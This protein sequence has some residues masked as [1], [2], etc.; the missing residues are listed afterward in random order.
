MQQAALK[1]D[2]LSKLAEEFLSQK[3]IKALNNK[4]E[5][6]VLANGSEIT[7]LSLYLGTRIGLD[8]LEEGVRKLANRINAIDDKIEYALSHFLKLDLY[9]NEFD[10]LQ[11]KSQECVIVCYPLVSA[12]NYE[13]IMKN[14][15]QYGVFEMGAVP[16]ELT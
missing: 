8:K 12:K 14:P 7:H 9:Q 13:E 6:T 11:G 15:K 4:V 10:A 5:T 1:V 16:K 2:D 3:A